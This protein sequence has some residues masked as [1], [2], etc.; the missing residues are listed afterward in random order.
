MP[1]SSLVSKPTRTFGSVCRGS[2]RRTASRVAG[3]SFAA[4]PAA[5]AMDV[6]FT[7]DAKNAPRWFG[8]HYNDAA[9]VTVVTRPDGGDVGAKSCAGLVN[10]VSSPDALGLLARLYCA[11]CALAVAWPLAVA[12]A[13]G[14]STDGEARA[15][16][17]L[18]FDDRVSVAGGRGSC[19]AGVG[20]GIDS[21]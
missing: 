11:R 2:L 15:A 19:L 18:C 4:Q 17:A 21:K 9:S 5:L 13:D 7:C 6:S 8:N 16:F 10:V 3:F 14:D 20:T 1:A 12:K